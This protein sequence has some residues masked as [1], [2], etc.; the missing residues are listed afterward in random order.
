MRKLSLTTTLSH[1]GK[2]LDQVLAD[3]LPVALG[4][5]VS[6]AG[7]RKLIVA[8]A[9]YLNRR[10]VRIASKNIL[11]RARIEVFYEGEKLKTISRDRP[12][13][14]SKAHILFEDEFLIAIDK[15]PGLPT[16]PT[17]D[18]ARANL[19]AAVKRY[20]GPQAYV[21]LHHRLDRDTSGVVLFTKAKASNAGVAEAFAKHLARK[22]Y[23]ALAKGQAPKPEWKVENFLAR[24]KPS[25]R[26]HSVRAGGDPART[27][28]RVVEKLAGASLVEA[29]PLTGR[30]HQIRV[31]LA[32][33]GT[34]ILGDDLYGGGDRESVPRLMLHARRLE[35]RHPV[36]RAELS[37][38]SPV[39]ADFEIALERLR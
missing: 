23:L 38:E 29:R 13:E 1:Q 15:P 14:M 11:A 32:E 9:V 5:P 19:Y 27:E 25:Q 7:V 22:T 26:Y 4:E 34:P 28:F 6:K 31:H 21:G 24:E 33:G 10:R 18:E 12:F 17:I 30:T 8:G 16:Q 37:L 3:W 39:P 20:L 36:T 35:L 2:R